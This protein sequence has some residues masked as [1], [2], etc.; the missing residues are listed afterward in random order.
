MDV[1]SYSRGAVIFKEGDSG[2]CMYEIQSGCIGIFK[3]YGGPNEKR[4]AFLTA[5]DI[6]GEMG[7]LDNAPRSA[8]AVAMEHDTVLLCVKEADFNEYFW[9]NPSR[10]LLLMQQMCARLRNT[11]QDYLRA[12][13]TVHE[14]VEAEKTG[15]EK[16]GSLLERIKRICDFYNGFDFYGDV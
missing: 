2:D 16:S 4:I 5:S 1:K 15:K 14:T 9:K 8:T 12:C 7:F 3:D 11:T 6:F 10:V 13:R